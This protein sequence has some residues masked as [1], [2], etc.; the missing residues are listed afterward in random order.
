MNFIKISGFIACMIPLLAVG[1]EN[2]FSIGPRLGVNYST[3]SNV[4]D[5]DSKIGLVGGVTMTYSVNATS[6]ITGEILYSQE[7]YSFDDTD[8][9]LDYIDIPIY[10]NL[11]F[12]DLGEA[13]RP[14]VYVGVVPGFLI[15]A[16]QDDTDYSDFINPF[17]F[18][19]S[20]GLGFNYRLASRVWLNADLR[21]YLGLTDIREKDFQEGDTQANRNIQL[22]VGV[23]Y[24]LSKL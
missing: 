10:Y 20:G 1:Q 4:D 14:K 13:F 8:A 17:N 21:A 15:S 3:V 16:K 5:I 23:A 22:S 19:V 18:G 2:A 11:F 24:G 6:G 7:G 9:K 12:A